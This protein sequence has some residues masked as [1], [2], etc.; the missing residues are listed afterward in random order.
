MRRIG[1]FA[2]MFALLALAGAF[3]VSS[4]AFA[5]PGAK[6]KLTKVEFDSFAANGDVV[7]KFTGT[8]F[9][10]GVVGTAKPDKDVLRLATTYVSSTS[11]K[12]SWGIDNFYKDGRVQN[13]PFAVINSDGAESDA[14]PYRLA[15]PKPTIASLAPA[16]FDV[17]ATARTV[18]VTGTNFSKKA[19]IKV[20][21][22]ERTVT[23]V[24][25]TSLK[26]DL[27]AE[28]VASARTHEVVAVNPED[29]ASDKM[30]IEVIALPAITSLTPNVV[31]MTADPVVVTVAGTGFRN[32]DKIHLEGDN[33]AVNAGCTTTFV[34]ATELRCSTWSTLTLKVRTFDFKVA[35]GTTK[36]APTPFTV[37]NPVPTLTK[38]EISPIPQAFPARGANDVVLRLTGGMFVAG[39]TVSPLDRPET[40]LAFKLA[41]SNV[42]D[43]LVPFDELFRDGVL[44]EIKLFVTNPA[45]G[46]GS[47]GALPYR[48]AFAKPIVS[49]LSPASVAVGQAARTVTVTGAFFNPKTV[50]RVGG[51]DRVT[52]YVSGSSVKFDLADADVASPRDLD[53]TAANP[54][55]VV[56][57]K[58]ALPVAYP[59]PTI[60]S[61]AP[62]SWTIGGDVTLDVTGTNFI[63]G[64]SVLAYRDG[65][66]GETVLADI[67]VPAD[68]SSTSF[69]VTVPA[70]K[71]RANIYTPRIYV[72]N[73]PNKQST[74][75]FPT[76]VKPPIVITSIEPTTVE[77]GS[78]FT[79]KVR[80]TAIEHYET[81]YGRF[82]DSGY[83][84]T[85]PAAGEVS[86][87]VHGTTVRTPGTYKVRLNYRTPTGYV[88]SNELDFVVGAQRPKLTKVE[89]DST[90]D[91]GR[92]VLKLTGSGFVDGATGTQAAQDAP[93]YPTT[94]VSGTQLKILVPLA[95]LL[96]D[97]KAATV[98]FKAV[99]P[100]GKETDAQPFKLEFPKPA[101]TSLAP[102][103][104][105]VGASAATVAARGT[106][107]ATG[108]V[109]RVGGTDRVTRRL[110]ATELS[111]D[112]TTADLAASGELSVT[113]R[114][115]DGEETGTK[116]FT[117]AHPTPALAS[118]SHVRKLVGE[119]GFELTLV[120]EGFS[121]SSI[122]RFG[123]SAR[124]VI[125]AAPTELKIV[126]RTED[127]DEVGTFDVEVENPAPGGGVTDAL[128][129]EVVN[130]VP[131]LDTYAPFQAYA[132]DAATPFVL[133]GSAFVPS[134]VVRIGGVDVPTTYVSS[135]ELR[136]TMP[137]SKLAATGIVPV[138]VFTPAPGGG[139]SQTLGFTVVTRPG[140][141]ILAP[142]DG[143]TLQSGSTYV[144]RWEVVG[145]SYD[146]VRLS[147]AK[148]GEEY[149]VVSSNAGTTGSFSWNVPSATSDLVTLTADFFLNGALVASDE[150]RDL[151][152]GAAPAP[153]PEPQPEP[154]PAPAPDPTPAPEPAPTPAPT[155][156]PGP[157][158]TP[159]PAPTPGTP[160]T[161]G[162]G[163]GGT[164]PTDIPP[165]APGS[166]PNPR[167]ENILRPVDTPEGERYD[168][169]P[170]E[171]FA[172]TEGDWI[173]WTQT[174]PTSDPACGLRKTLYKKANVDTVWYCGWDGRLHA[175]QNP[176][177][178]FSWY[179][180]FGNVK[181]ISSAILDALPKGDPVQ[182]RP[183]VR[184]IKTPDAPTVYAVDKDWILRPI[185]DEAT[186]RALYGADWAKR[187][188]DV[189]SA[190][191]TRYR[192]GE[193]IKQDEP[194]F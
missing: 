6:P 92:I 88:L 104:A 165:S 78:A 133:S 12:V 125:S 85:R 127:M 168:Y 33:G 192:V 29:V 10:S 183:G 109:V 115:P 112:L 149:A 81:V 162:G 163:G 69:T 175:F 136:A 60:T 15:L 114:N 110:S 86:W 18:T 3:F 20:G 124:R 63:P 193:R 173:D 25:S 108:A 107:F 72:L 44:A 143:E 122:V 151:R 186:A 144:I 177:I 49:S 93:T 152:F 170:A 135:T 80:G 2:S 166:D 123:G 134:S 74:N 113:V 145:T 37:Q 1:M 179:A 180:G 141:T 184:L 71:V 36:Y 65:A 101:L 120:G 142:E 87:P 95:D 31:G 55:N 172:R 157:S 161:G 22:A 155:P 176:K 132:G 164:P 50:I 83:T 106:G 73:P 54:G 117:V 52:T 129:F 167:A 189:P 30:G 94:F 7:L 8:D 68:A 57:D 97:G 147:L 16:S 178:Y 24:S 105:L 4:P 42:L 35:R 66:R 26:F 5:A 111:F 91:D 118:L 59:A 77:A 32:G 153:A 119:T 23:W 194:G 45:P 130:P 90:A 46:G 56:S 156:T 9:R 58:R 169:D 174:L 89:Y 96:R 21:G 38:I 43:V 128:E 160:S 138:L 100:D 181:I 102:D 62:S 61:F 148:N 171:V 150:A 19:K 187:V 140:A 82:E 126:V 11:L 190:F 79:I 137:A 99:N 182:Y 116:T 40:K 51:E 39:S 191:F 131:A 185:P 53:V 13:I 47:S 158:P 139:T 17:G 34:S 27:T 159:T 28:D 121:R 64:V 70:D 67:T 41:A 146:R 154:E 84:V 76:L 98:P 14:Q 188:D 48:H 75:R 103:R